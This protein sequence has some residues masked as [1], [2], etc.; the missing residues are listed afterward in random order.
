MVDEVP[1]TI[2]QASN[3]TLMSI[4]THFSESKPGRTLSYSDCNSELNL[5]FGIG[6]VLGGVERDTNRL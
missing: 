4:Q 2:S 6:E 1:N 5:G 3:F